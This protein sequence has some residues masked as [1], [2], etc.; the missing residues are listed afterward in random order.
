[1]TLALRNYGLVLPKNY[2]SIEKDEMEYIDGG[3]DIKF[4]GLKTAWV[5]PVG[6]YL[7]ISG[8]VSDLAWIVAGGA[9]LA[10]TIIG[11]LACTGGGSAFIPK[12]LVCVSAIIAFAAAIV[13]TNDIAVNT[14]FSKTF[15]LGY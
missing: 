13:A 6:I 10:A 2:V 14:K 7:N 1:M 9:A 3:W 8:S 15:Y 5:I 12:V 4:A 11:I